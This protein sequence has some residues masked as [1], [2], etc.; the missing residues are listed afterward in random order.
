MGDNGYVNII[1]TQHMYM[2]AGVQV[3]KSNN[4][5]QIETYIVIQ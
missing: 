1:T 4:R 3:S 2:S 5:V